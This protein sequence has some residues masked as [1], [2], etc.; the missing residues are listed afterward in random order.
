MSNTVI[1]AEARIQKRIRLDSRWSLP[2]TLACRQDR[3]DTG[4]E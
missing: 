3:L 4:R 1:L 2:R